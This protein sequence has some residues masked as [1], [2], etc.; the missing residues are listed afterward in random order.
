MTEKSPLD[1]QTLRA[2]LTP[3]QYQICREHGT[4]RAFTGKY[5]N[6][7]DA[8]TY[9]CACCGAP[10]FDADSKFDS[11][12]GWPS[13]W[14]PIIESAVETSHDNSLLM[15]RTEVHCRHCGSHLGHIFEDG[16]APTELR[17]CI[18]SASLDFEAKK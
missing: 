15:P 14:Q 3:E 7:K 13:F 16:P 5:W 18:N 1:E 11:G 4:E 17:Y 8:G 2:K 6:L 12:T 10:L 9:R